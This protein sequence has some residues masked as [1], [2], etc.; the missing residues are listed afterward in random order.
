MSPVLTGLLSLKITPLR[1]H[2]STP[3]PPF[4]LLV[5]WK[6]G[7]QLGFRTVETRVEFLRVRRA[8]LLLGRRE[9]TAAQF[10]GCPGLSQG[11]GGTT[12]IRGIGVCLLFLLGGVGESVL[13]CKAD[14]PSVK[15]RTAFSPF[16][17]PAAF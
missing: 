2:C 1:V 3:P 9:V 14:L 12:S 6:V 17:V 5:S 16:R 8:G 11:R 4:R 7:F 13:R 15:A 10:L